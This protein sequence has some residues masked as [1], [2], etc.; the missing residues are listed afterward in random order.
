MSDPDVLAF[1]L[2]G[3][4][5]SRLDLLT[6]SRAKPAVPFAGG[7]R[8][9][10][11]P[12][13]NCLHSRISDVW[14]AQQYQPA[15]LNDHL[16]NGRP[17]DLDRTSGGLLVLPPYQGDEREGWTKGTADGLWRNAALIRQIDPELVV[18][19]SADAVYRLDYR[20][21]VRAHVDSGA[22]MTMV[23]THVDIDDAGR[24]GVVQVDGDETGGRIRDYAYKP[25]EPAGDLVTNEVFVFSTG[26]VL[27]LLER[28]ADATDDDDEEGLGDLGDRLL[29]EL[30]ADGSVRSYAQP[31]YWRDVGTIDA[32]WEANMDFLSD[33]PPFDLDDPS[34][35]VRTQGGL[36][37]PAWVTDSA[38]VR[39]SL[40][41]SAAQVA[42]DVRHSVLAPRAV[43]ERGA[44][45]V[46]SILL[47][48]CRVRA[49]ARVERAIVDDNVVVGRDAQ[50]GG[51]DA[52]TLLGRRVEI[53]EGSTVKAGARVPEDDD[54]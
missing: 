45:V 37:S 39:T 11:F 4:Q 32:Y 46:D 31:G 14:V 36:R 26:P 7:Y 38:S 5:G 8:L 19:V 54:D 22:V 10:D 2:A 20:D 33:Y 30:V 42:G 27:D 25:D 15:S 16:S 3:G 44:T 47:P 24:Y 28:L 48:G 1:V 18:L 41:S 50:V 13:S 35:A 9:I 40:L 17:W 21:V 34:W 52:I 6:A 53:E 12:L 43:V 29:P 51:A 49:G 23:T